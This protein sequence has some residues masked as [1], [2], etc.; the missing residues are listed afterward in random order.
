MVAMINCRLIIRQLLAFSKFLRIHSISYFLRSMIH[1]G[2]KIS[3]TFGVPNAE[4]PRSRVRQIYSYRRI[5]LCRG[6]AIMLTEIDALLCDLTESF[7]RNELYD[8][9]PLIDCDRNTF[10]PS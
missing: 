4:C 2:L 5:K 10:V 7:L 8:S 3:E 1:S 9:L 6:A